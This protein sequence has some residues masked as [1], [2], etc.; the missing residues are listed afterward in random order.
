MYLDLE[1]LLTGATGQTTTAGTVV[2]TDHV[3]TLAAGDAISPGARAVARIYT[4]FVDAAGGTIVC[5]LETC[6]EN[7][8]AAA[9][10]LLTGPTITIPA[11]AADPAGAPGVVLLDAVIPSGVL[12][13]V[14]FRFTFSV[15]MDAGAIEAFIALDTDKLLDRGL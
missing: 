8:F 14:Q 5:T 12:Q 13:Y 6:A 10:T 3:D 4:Q 1:L 2:S 7:T 9:T 15:N 11:G